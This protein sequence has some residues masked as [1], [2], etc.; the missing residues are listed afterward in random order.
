MIGQVVS[1]ERILNCVGERVR[2]VMRETRAVKFKHPKVVL[3]ER[4]TPTC[5]V[6][7]LYLLSLLLPLP[8]AAQDGARVSLSLDSLKK[9]TYFSLSGVEW[10]Y[11]S[12]D[13][14]S[15]ASPTFDD[16]KWIA[17]KPTLDLDSV[18][19]G[20]WTGIGWF[21]FHLFVDSTLRNKTVALRMSHDGASEI[22]LD[23]QLVQR[24]GTVS[25]SEK[26]ERTF[27][28]RYIPF[29]LHLNSDSE[30]TLAVRYSNHRGEKIKS[31]YGRLAGVQGLHILVS[32]LN[33]SIEAYAFWQKYASVFGAGAVGIL[34]LLT[35]LHLI[36]FLLYKKDKSNLCFAI[37]CAVMACY[38]F[39]AF[40]PSTTHWE[41]EITMWLEY[42]LEPVFGILAIPSFA[43]VMYLVFYSKIQ[44]QFWFILFICALAIVVQIWQPDW[45]RGIV[46]AILFTIVG[47]E[48]L[49]VIGRAFLRKQDGIWAF[50]IG[51]ILTGLA[52]G[53]GLLLGFRII[54]DSYRDILISFANCGIILPMPIAMSVFLATRFARTSKKLE[55][56]LI[57]VKEL[58]E[59]Q[60]AVEQEK[61]K[62]IEA[63]KE[64]LE[65][66]VAERTKELRKEKEETERLLYNILPVEI[67]RELKEKGTT[68]PRRYEEITIIF[69]DFRGFTNTVATMPANKLVEELNDIFRD[70]DD[71]IDKYG[72]EKIKTIGDSYMIA[73][74]LPKESE[75]H[76][77]QCVRAAIE[78][79]Q[80]LERRNRDS[81][82]KWQ[83]R[84]GIHSGTAVAGV[85]GKRKFTYDVWGDTV[86]I[87]SRMETSGQ[88][89]KV[90]ISAYTYALIKQYF[91]CEYRGKVDAKGKGEI[92]MYFV[93][94]EK[95]EREQ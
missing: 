34:A 68:I 91:E 42:I 19:K 55:E 93:V 18:P 44:K 30:H 35:F 41:W 33:S 59:R 46:S 85:V 57:Q 38:S 7:C 90:N 70:I 13:D 8:L 40:V 50:G 37:F 63:Q 54:P 1:H 79:L 27:R 24:F 16:R 89:G 31:R 2:S 58:S 32:E 29:G 45:R 77:V 3:S 83:M 48:M 74:G 95:A 28:P 20:A 84:V 94:G 53:L 36:L 62:L 66:E 76:A 43:A 11:Q 65:I 17:L 56:Q 60:L 39:L 64:K 69:T 12:G 67:A 75:N 73:A 6:V 78:M 52:G 51:G 82:V 61:K 47:F 86:N 23:N 49:R 92:D 15:W 72:L 22:Y 80:F 88:P 71:I 5:V 4:S 9:N 21:R 81:A 10:K 25:S 87:A 26:N 14:T